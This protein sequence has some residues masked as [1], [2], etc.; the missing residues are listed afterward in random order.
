MIRR[1]CPRCKTSWYS[2]RKGGWGCKLCGMR[3]SSKHDKPL[4]EGG[5]QYEG[6][7]EY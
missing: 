3:L 6:K 5:G 7:R 4:E 1:E 2:M